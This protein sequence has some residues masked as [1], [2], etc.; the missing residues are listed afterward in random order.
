MP[1]G[2]STRMAMRPAFTVV[3][4]KMPHGRSIAAAQILCGCRL[5][6]GLNCPIGP[7]V[8]DVHFTCKT[9]KLVRNT[10][11]RRITFWIQ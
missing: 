8:L 5:A 2:H 6:R 9:T 3:R 4:G 7:Y 11:Q 1:C 10:K